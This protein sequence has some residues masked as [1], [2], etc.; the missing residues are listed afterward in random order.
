MALLDLCIDPGGSDSRNVFRVNKR[1]SQ[2]L[3]M[4]SELRKMSADSIN[5]Q[6]S[7]NS[8]PAQNA[9]V[10]IN[11]SDTPIAVGFLAKNNYGRVRLDLPKYSLAVYKIL[12]A[13][14]AL[15]TSYK[16]KKIR[17]S[18]SVLLPY[19]ELGNREDLLEQLNSALKGFYFQSKKYQV[20]LEEFECVPEGYGLFTL[21]E[22]LLENEQ[23]QGKD[24]TVLM[25]G[26]RN[27]SCLTFRDGV[28]LKQHSAT[29]DIGFHRLR[30]ILCEYRPG[31]KPEIIGKV[32]SRL[33]FSSIRIS[34]NDPINI[35]PEQRDIGW[36]A[37]AAGYTAADDREKIVSA[38]TRAKQDCWFLL[39][40]WLDT[41]FPSST[42]G[43]I[44]SG[45]ASHFW[46][47]NIIKEFQWI[48]TSLIYWLNEWI[49]HIRNTFDLSSVGS[50]IDQELMAYRLLDAYGYWCDL[51]GSLATL[52]PGAKVVN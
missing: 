3:L 27:T 29:T 40:E 49:P 28:L 41:V 50:E 20:K 33:A 52:Q 2:L 25:F 14:G 15:A 32:L 47:D 35:C 8:N 48:P 37:Y 46:R 13:I 4:D 18:L 42:S 10:R 16:L 39:S 1:E 6:V 19:A 12:A 26:E 31:L 51:T 24:L 44:I 5:N 36:L 9:W 38:I 22:S 43:L 23:F 17:L 30:E 7:T 45:G 11:E 34:P 21:A